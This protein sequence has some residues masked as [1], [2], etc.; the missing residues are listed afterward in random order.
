MNWKRLLR[1]ICWS[2]TRFA[3]IYPIGGHAYKELG[4]EK[5][6]DRYHHVFE[7]NRCGFVNDTAW[8]EN[9]AEAGFVTAR[10]LEDIK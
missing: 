2:R 5:R 8:H 10:E 7:C 4:W 1:P 3:G 9:P 6:G